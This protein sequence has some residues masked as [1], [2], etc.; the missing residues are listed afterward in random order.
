MYGKIVTSKNKIGYVELIQSKEQKKKRT[1][2]QREI[3][4][5][6]YIALI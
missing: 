1:K 5:E 4:T 6:K 3:S 2:E